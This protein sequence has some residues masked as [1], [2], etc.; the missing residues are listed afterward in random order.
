MGN[1][2]LKIFMTYDTSNKLDIATIAKPVRIMMPRCTPSA[3]Q[4]PYNRFEPPF[5]TQM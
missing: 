1:C 4:Q 5:N 2:L 3:P